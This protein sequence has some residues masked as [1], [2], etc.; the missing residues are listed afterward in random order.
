MLVILGCLVR[1]VSKNHHR[2]VRS[3]PNSGDIAQR[4][5]VEGQGPEKRERGG[6][7]AFPLSYK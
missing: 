7:K 4:V 1:W 3:H 6:Q 2:S 5:E